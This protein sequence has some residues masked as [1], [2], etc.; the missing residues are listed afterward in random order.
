M[1]KSQKVFFSVADRGLESSIDYDTFERSLVYNSM[2]QPGLVIPDIFIFISQNLKHHFSESKNRKNLF[3][4][5]IEN[6]YIVPAFRNRNVKSFDDALQ[7]IQ[8]KGDQKRAIQ[9]VQ[10]ES[11]KLAACLDRAC[12]NSD[13]CPEYW[14]PKDV[15]NEFD[16]VV[17]DYL[18]KG[19]PK[20]KSL[21]DLDSSPE[22]LCDLWTRTEKWRTVC[23]DEARDK[24]N[25]IAGKGLRRGEIWNAVGRDLGFHENHKVHNVR[26]L[27]NN[28]KKQE[29]YRPLCYFI[30][31]VNDCYHYNLT[32]EL[33]AVRSLPAYDPIGCLT[34]P[35]MPYEDQIITDLQPVPTIREKVPLPPIDVLLKMSPDDL[36]QAR[37]KCGTGYMAAVEFWQQQ[38]NVKNE[39]EVSE[40]L[41]LYAKDINEH[42]AQKTDTIAEVIIGATPTRKLI[43]A[44]SGIGIA[45]ASM[46]QPFIAPFVSVAAAGYVGYQLFKTRPKNTLIEV[47]ARAIP[48]TISPEI[49]LIDKI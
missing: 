23:V 16:K 15:G 7:E 3:E 18:V 33:K 21:F 37:N 31:W 14:P 41:R 6:N 2:F 1:K 46:W 49:N 47:K 45:A 19:S 26:E 43:T 20:L 25:E 32:R 8:A 17:E 30:R 24:T 11:E 34:V 4:A 36:I 35:D 5:C 13:F 40:C 28:I 42:V 39:N 22:K 12:E 9:G 29:D 10:Q 27:L 38:P 48:V 44:A